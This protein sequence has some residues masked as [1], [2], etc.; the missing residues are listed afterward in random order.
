[1]EGKQ[2]ELPEKHRSMGVLSYVGNVK[3]VAVRF[4]E[5]Y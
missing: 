1:M 4:G 3:Q 5:N 2:R